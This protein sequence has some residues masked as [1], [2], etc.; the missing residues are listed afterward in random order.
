MKRLEAE[1]WALDNCAGCGLAVP[2]A[3]INVI[4]AGE[5]AL[6]TLLLVT[7]GLVGHSLAV[8]LGRPL[9]FEPDRL[10]SFRYVVARDEFIEPAGFDGVQ[11]VVNLNGVPAAAVARQGRVR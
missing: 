6:A 4:V 9:N 2:H 5:M 8:V 1:V 10:G 7:A 3:T 11:P